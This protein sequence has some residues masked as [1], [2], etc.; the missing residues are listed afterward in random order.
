MT[1]T[2]N[3]ETGSSHKP[4]AQVLRIAGLSLFV[5]LA[6]AVLLVAG[7][8]RV[9]AQPIGPQTGYLSGG[10]PEDAFLPASPQ[11]A[12]K[13][14]GQSPEL[15]D[16]PQPGPEGAPQR[17]QIGRHGS[18]G[19]RSESAGETGS[20]GYRPMFKMLKIEDQRK[21]ADLRIS[22]LKQAGPFESDLKVKTAELAA[23]WLADEPNEDQIIAKA[24]EI[25]A[26]KEQLDE[27]R[28]RNRIALLKILPPE[29]RRMFSMPGAQG[30]G[31]RRLGARAGGRGFGGRA[32]QFH[33]R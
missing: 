8:G 32:R 17:S 16:L 11:F 13:P 6:L 25:D 29:A 19:W 26:V 20:V 15:A 9:N 10:T 1:R 7:P 22:F 12:L 27:L 5:L 31:S 33:D 30:T 23:L 21:L 18:T 14:D 28:L 4:H 2:L 24:K 3:N